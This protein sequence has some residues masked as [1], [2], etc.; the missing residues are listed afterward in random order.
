MEEN[1]EI[2]GIVE[3]LLKSVLQGKRKKRR[4]PPAKP[5]MKVD[6]P[7]PGSPHGVYTYDPISKTWVLETVDGEWRPSGTGLLFIYF[8]NTRC[9]ACRLYDKYWF[10][11]AERRGDELKLSIVLCAWFAHDCRSESAKKMFREYD[12][13]ASPTTLILCLKNGE[14][15]VIGKHEGVL[16]LEEL[17]AIHAASRRMCGAR[18][19]ENP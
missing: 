1:E 6:R 15:V 4:I 3:R 5:G 12:V 9:P 13:H 7:G 10:E 16:R 2:K 14:T 19:S 18:S 8:D 17:I 11:F